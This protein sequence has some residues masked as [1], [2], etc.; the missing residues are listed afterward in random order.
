MLGTILYTFTDM[1]LWWVPDE[2]FG[3]RSFL[4]TSVFQYRS[5]SNLAF[6]NIKTSLVA[7]SQNKV[8]QNE[9]ERVEM[10]RGEGRWRK[11]GSQLWGRRA[12]PRARA[13]AAAFGLARAL[14]SPVVRSMGHKG[15][16]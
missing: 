14:P 1:S 6:N 5:H 13:Q 16:P 2:D 11:S 10:V 7:S 3:D 9:G 12:F 15:I 8:T 4:H